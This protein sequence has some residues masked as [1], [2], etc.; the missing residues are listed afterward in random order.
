MI[1]EGIG[2]LQWPKLTLGLYNFNIVLSAKYK[3]FFFINVIGDYSFLIHQ[4]LI[5]L[6]NCFL[7]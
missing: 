2:E 3:Y 5:S 7:K 1:T 6:I 4:A